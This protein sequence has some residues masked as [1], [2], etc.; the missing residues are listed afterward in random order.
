VFP[1]LSHPWLSCGLLL[2]CFVP[3]LSVW[4]VWYLL[5]IRLGRWHKWGCCPECMMMAMC[6]PGDVSLDC[7]LK[8][9]LLSLSTVKLPFSPLEVIDYFGH[10]TFETTQ[11]WHFCLNLCPFI[12][13]VVS[14]FWVQQLFL[15]YFNGDH[16][17]TDDPSFYIC[18]LKRLYKSCHFPLVVR[19][20][21]GFF[22]F[23]GK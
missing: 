5:L 8:P 7:W 1:C 16:L 10:D 17:F 3:C 22:F 18:H 20:I 2:S 19:R 11:R 12:L 13:A 23:F 4:V 15:W 9:C 6:L 21:L 14:E